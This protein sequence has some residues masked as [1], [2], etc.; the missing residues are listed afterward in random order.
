MV[1][2]TTDADYNVSFVSNTMTAP[3]QPTVIPLVLNEDNSSEYV[4][5]EGRIMLPYEEVVF[6]SQSLSSR[7]VNIN[8]F[9]VVKWDG[10]LDIDPNNDIWVEMIDKPTIFDSRTEFVDGAVFVPPPQPSV[11]AYVLLFREID[12]SPVGGGQLKYQLTEN[13]PQSIDYLRRLD[14]AQGRAGR[15]IS[16]QVMTGSSFREIQQNLIDNLG[17]GDTANAFMVNLYTGYTP[18]GTSMLIKR[19]LAGSDYVETTL[20]TL[21]PGGDVRG[22]SNT[23]IGREYI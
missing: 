9:A 2:Q 8:P 5:I 6:A 7:I 12:N 10:M 19:Q 17:K 18:S 22:N 3:I 21:T 20:R 14:E 13:N 4:N 1:N 11:E 23:V 15:Y 16:A